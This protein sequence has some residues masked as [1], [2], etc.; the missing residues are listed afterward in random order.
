MACCSAVNAGRIFGHLLVAPSLM[1]RVYR[2]RIGAPRALHNSIRQAGTLFLFAFAVGAVHATPIVVPPGLAPG[3]QYRLAFVTAGTRNA[4]SS[5]IADYNL[6]VT[7]EAN[8]SS[9]LAALGTSW[10]VIGSTSAK[11][12]Y[13]NIGGNFTIPIYN[14]AG[15][16][17]ATGATDLWDGTIANPIG[18]NQYGASYSGTVFTGTTFDGSGS[19]FGLGSPSVTTGSSSLVVAFWISGPTSPSTLTHPFYAISG[20]LTVPTPEPSALGMTILSLVLG[21]VLNQARRLRRNKGPAP[22]AASW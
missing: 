4:G 10:A 20:T 1:V 19:S 16:L 5:Q 9:G 18:W 6:F 22:G 12:A 2:T 14:L 3:S 21:L 11:Y 7:T 8:L 15:Q 17:V 13:D